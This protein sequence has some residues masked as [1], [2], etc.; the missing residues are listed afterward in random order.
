MPYPETAEGFMVHD[1]KNWSTFK[2]GEFKLK[3]FG[4]RDVDVAIDGAS[5]RRPVSSLQC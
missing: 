5:Q 4:E 3:S 1:H 2:K